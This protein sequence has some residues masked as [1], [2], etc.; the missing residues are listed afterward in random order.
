[1]SE[2]GIPAAGVVALGGRIDLFDDHGWVSAA[3]QSVANN[4][5]VA[6]PQSLDLF[7]WF[8]IGSAGGLENILQAVGVHYF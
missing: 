4:V 2:V 1:M 3:A 7:H 8:S 6:T 5:A